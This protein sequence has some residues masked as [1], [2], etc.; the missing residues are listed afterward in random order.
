LG[1]ITEQ[2]IEE[3]HKEF[4]PL[5][6]LKIDW[7]SLPTE[8]LPGF[9]PSQIAVIINTLLDAAMPQIELLSSDPE[10]LEKLKHIGLSKAPREIGERESY[11]DFIH[12]SGKRFELKGLFVDNTD[13]DLKRPPT[14][15]EP[16]AR[17]KEN[18]T[19]DNVNPSTDVLLVAAVQLREIDG[20]CY[21]IIID[22]GLFSMIKCVEARDKRLADSGGKWIGGV[23]KVISNTG[24]KK[25]KK[26]ETLSD[27]DFEKDTNFGK[28]NRIPYEPLQRFLSKHET[29]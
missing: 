15:R 23:P 11:P 8:S 10:N 2:E 19:I 16:S 9:E 12:K 1:I 24:R 6:G 29:P 22:I 28:L 3:L 7:L 27:L 13:L 18:I 14:R 4:L 5:I 17:I 21:P 25:M 20:R 26:G